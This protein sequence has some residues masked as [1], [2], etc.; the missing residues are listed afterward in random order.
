MVM[1][2]TEFERHGGQ[3]VMK[4]WKSS[5]YVSVCVWGREGQG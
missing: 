1:L 2:P 5:I 4:K 3:A